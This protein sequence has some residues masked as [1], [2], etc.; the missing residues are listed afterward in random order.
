M[1]FVRNIILALALFLPSIS[2][3]E[4][5]SVYTSKEKTSSYVP[6]FWGLEIG[7]GNLF[8]KAT[9]GNRRVM[10]STLSLPRIGLF[11]P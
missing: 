5:D 11:D 6:N 7:A 8:T 3:A 1:K 9:R 2:M 10:D 4:G